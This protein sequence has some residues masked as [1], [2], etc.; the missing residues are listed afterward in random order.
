MENFAMFFE[1]EE[2]VNDKIKLHKKIVVM[3]HKMLIE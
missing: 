1:V 2:T 3:M